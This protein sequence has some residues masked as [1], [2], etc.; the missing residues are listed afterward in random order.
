MPAGL[1]AVARAAVQV[2][3][4]TIEIRELALPEG[5]APGEALLRVEGCG[6]CGS[7]VEQ[8][9][10]ALSFVEYPLVPGHEPVGRIAAIDAEAKRRW[11]VDVGDRVA[12]G[13]ITA[14]CGTCA[15]CREGQPCLDAFL[16]GYRR[17]DAG[18]GLWGGYAEYLH[19]A[20]NTLLYPVAGDL[21]IEDAVLFNPIAAGFEWVRAAGT[22]VGDSILIEGP[23]QRG[24]SAV[25]AARE[26]GAAVIV[27]TGLA[28]D[29]DKLDLAVEFGATHIVDADEDDV[30]RAVRAATGG[31]GADAVLDTTPYATQPVIDG[32]R[33]ARHGGTIVLAGIKGGRT[34][35]DFPVDLVVLRTLRIVGVVGTSPWANRQAIRLVESGRYPLGKLHTHR[36]RIDDVDLAMRILAGEVEG[37][38]AIHI[39][40]TA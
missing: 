36:F 25:I 22:G 27:V 33:A 2:A 14:P 29:R 8:Y 17:T 3:D 37:E 20:P 28:Q 16:Y 1:P 24:L 35:P 15:R 9:T 4:R 38:R 34:V 7:D 21:S 6:M 40:I 12:V 32:L 10:G 39:T 30:V 18:S 31:C 23:G 26:A 13:N 11:G 5:L 19:L